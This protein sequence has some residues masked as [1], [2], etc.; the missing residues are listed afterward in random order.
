M[1]V[2]ELWQTFDF[3][4]GTGILLSSAFTMTVKLSTKNWPTSIISLYMTVKL[5]TKINMK[6]ISFKPGVFTQSS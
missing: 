2:C 5:S 6:N 1:F 3:L 4:I